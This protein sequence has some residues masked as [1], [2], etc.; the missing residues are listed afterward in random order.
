MIYTTRCDWEHIKTMMIR[1]GFRRARTTRHS[2][3]VRTLNCTDFQLLQPSPGLSISIHSSLPIINAYNNASQLSATASSNSFM[4][5][6]SS[7]PSV[8]DDLKKPPPVVS[9]IS[10]NANDLGVPSEEESI[11]IFFAKIHP[12][13]RS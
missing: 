6:Y 5:M 8:E 2:V 11:S 10:D 13:C 3:P 12:S 7:K 9:S 4:K 1:N